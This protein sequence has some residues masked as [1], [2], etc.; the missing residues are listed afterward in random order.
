MSDGNKLA[1]DRL[2]QLVL[3]SEDWL[4]GRILKYAQARGYTKYTSTLKEAWRLSVSGLS[5]SLLIAIDLG[6]EK[7]EL[8]PEEDYGADPVASFGVL[9]AKLHRERGVNLGMF[10]SLM[11]YYRQTYLDLIYEAG[12]TPDYLQHCRLTVIRFFDR[13]ELGFCT[14]WASQG[15]GEKTNELQYKNRD[16]TNEKNKYL[17]IFE[18]LQDPAILLDADNRV[19]NINH[20]W[21]KLFEGEAMPGSVYYDEKPVERNLPWLA[22]ELRVAVKEGTG[23]QVL[24]KTMET[25]RGPRDFFVKIKQMQDVSNKFVGAVVLLTDITDLKHLHASLQE[26]ERLQGV[27]EMAGAVCHEMNQPLMAI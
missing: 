8:L 7:L 1:P 17:T 20:A 23:E 24:E 2:R 5:K 19:V 15:E 14:E 26:R 13:V 4:M 18:S 12:F 16:M 21:I 22:E 9:E 3:D 10:L 25:V 11:K 6:L 27:L